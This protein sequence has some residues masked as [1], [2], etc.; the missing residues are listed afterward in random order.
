[1]AA[2]AAPAAVGDAAQE[3]GDVP[4]LCGCQEEQR[5]AGAG[6]KERVGDN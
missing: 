2:E 1:M 4:A 6:G 5:L 3:Q